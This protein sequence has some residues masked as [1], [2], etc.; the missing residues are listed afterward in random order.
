[1]NRKYVHYG[2]DHFDLDKFK[3]KINLG[4]DNYYLNKPPYGLWGSPVCTD[5][6]WRDWCEGEEFHLDSLNS[7]FIF[8]V[9][10]TAK[11]LTVKKDKDIWKYLKQYPKMHS[12]YL[13]FNV[14]MKEYDGME[15]IHA[16]NYWELHTNPGRFNMWDVDSI[17]IWNP[18]VIIENGEEA[19]EH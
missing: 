10:D 2:N 12:S 11:I 3:E 9:K 18:N 1:M 6:S 13:D 8:S 5:L 16:D 17:V 19:Y 14:I 15:L 4:R 7:H